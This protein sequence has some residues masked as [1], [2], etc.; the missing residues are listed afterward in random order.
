MELTARIIMER[1][2]LFRNIC[3]FLLATVVLFGVNP[4][5]GAPPQDFVSKL[6][7]QP[8]VEFKQYAGYV[9]VDESKGR[10]FF[11]YFVEATRDPHLKPLA[12]WL[13]GGEFK[14][15]PLEACTALCMENP[16]HAAMWRI[17]WFASVSDFVDQQL[18]SLSLSRFRGVRCNRCLSDLISPS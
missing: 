18:L 11:Y 4:A 5:R 10:A 3:L 6:P 1:L 17:L 13:N 12:L 2:S 9:T 7:G 14:S 15:I 8:S 16:S